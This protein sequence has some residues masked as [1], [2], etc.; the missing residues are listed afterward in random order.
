VTLRLYYHPLSSFCWK[1]IIALYEKGTRFEPVLVNLGDPDSRSAFLRLWPIGKFPVLKDEAR[2]WMVPESTIIIEYLEQHYPGGT[3]LLPT[4]PDRA[5]QVRMRDRFFDLYVHHPM[6]E[7]VGD[8][9]R[10]DGKR[11][12]FG[13]EQARA[14][15]RT[16]LGMVESD[17]G[18]RWLMGD[19]FSMADC[20]AMPALFYA[21]KVMPLEGKYDKTLAYLERL[22]AR[23]S[24]ARTLAEAEPYFH[25]FPQE[26]AA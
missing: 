20:S 22:K 6:Q 21:N 16:S 12:P 14:R 7:I 1:A 18:A 15:L 10:P 8:R 17:I 9:I 23:P 2:D 4:D 25:M 24:V 3:T 11:D 13:V 5:R 19:E 26:Q